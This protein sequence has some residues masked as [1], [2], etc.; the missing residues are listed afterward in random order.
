VGEVLL[1]HPPLRWGRLVWV[2]LASVTIVGLVGLRWAWREE[3][4]EPQRRRTCPKCRGTRHL[5][6]H[7]GPPL[8]ESEAIWQRAYDADRRRS[9]LEQAA[10]AAGAILVTAAA[11]TAI[12]FMVR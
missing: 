12:Y 8:A 5:A 10:L 7:D 2:L 4:I 11:A 6:P 9:L 3:E 1:A